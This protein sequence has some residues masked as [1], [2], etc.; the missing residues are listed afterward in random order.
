MLSM[1]LVFELL[2][3]VGLVCILLAQA[4]NRKYYLSSDIL[5][6]VGSVVLVLWAFVFHA[7]AIF[8]LDLVWSIIAS[9]Q[10]V[11]DLKTKGEK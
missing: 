4:I 5:N 2:S 6:I 9:I 8:I 3:Y 11:R 1:L 7:W 10:L